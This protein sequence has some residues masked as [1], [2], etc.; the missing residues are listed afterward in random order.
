MFRTPAVIAHPT[1][2]NAEGVRPRALPSRFRILMS[3]ALLAVL[4]AGIPPQH[5]AAQ[6]TRFLRQPDVSATHIVFVHANDLW[7]TGRDGGD[8]MRLTSSEGAETDPA[9]SA[10]GQWIAFSAQYGGNTD[11]Y[12]MPATGGQPRRLTWHPAADVVQGWTPDGEI[13]F[14]SGRDAVPTQLWKFYTVQPAGGLPAPLALPQ[15]YLGGMSGDGEYI[16][17]QE[18][19]YWDPEWRNYRG[20]Q[21]QPIGIVSTADWERATPSWEGERHMDPVWMDG[22]V[23]Y[24]SERDWAS[25]VWSYDPRTGAERQLTRHA[26]FDVKSLGAGEGR[27]GLRAGG[28]PARAG[29][30]VRAHARARDSRGGRHELVAGAL[31]VGSVRPDARRPPLPDRQAGALRVAR[32]DLQRARGGGLVAQPHPHPGGGRPA[33]GVVSR[34]VAH[35]L[36]QR[37]GRRVRARD[38]RAGRGEPAPHPDRRA[39]LLL[40]ARVVARREQAGLHRYPLPRAGAGRGVGRGGRTST[41]TASPTRSAP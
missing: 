35:R 17:Y 14:Q 29:S 33:S 15:A 27:G 32:R 40:P 1:T 2:R 11:V 37:R 19:G 4:N 8:A 36:V 18:I 7:L 3:C 39:L 13:L 41:P 38:R 22:V 10:D 24:M 6:G 12:L 34:R 31:G 25:N 23:Y 28:V 9:F 5:A 26:D 30:R 21:A 20:G 16:A